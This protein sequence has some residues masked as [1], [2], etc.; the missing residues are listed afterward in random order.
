MYVISKKTDNEGNVV[1]LFWSAKL[2]WWT[3]LSF[4]AK[5]Y[6]TRSRADSKL[7]Q[8][9]DDEAE[10]V[11]LAQPQVEVESSSYGEFNYYECI[12]L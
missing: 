11:D 9:N 10:V 4:E 8:I 7:K 1:Q 3:Q 5:Q 2:A 12:G 6:A